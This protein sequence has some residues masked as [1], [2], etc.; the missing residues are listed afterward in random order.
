[1]LTAT[2]LY[3]GRP[4]LAAA[5]RAGGGSRGVQLLLLVAGLG[6]VTAFSFV[7]ASASA[8]R[9]SLAGSLRV[10]RGQVV[11]YS[12]EHGDALPDLAAVSAV[13]QHFQPLT[14]VT[15]HD[16]RKRGPY[17]PAV[18]VNSLTG[19]SVVKDATS[20]RADG[21]PSP[22]PG[23]DFIYDYAGDAGTGRLWGTSDRATGAAVPDGQ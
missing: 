9:S 22:V 1:M 16:G 6:I 5:A 18:P 13:G 15:D 21:L 19:G 2:A 17:L 4:N 14:T 23:A 11:L 3:R 20:M 7:G 8:R 10:L 12:V